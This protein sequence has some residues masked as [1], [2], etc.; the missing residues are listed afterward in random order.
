VKVCWS[1]ALAKVLPPVSHP[2]ELG[3]PVVDLPL[4]PSASAKAE[5]L[6]RSYADRLVAEAKLVA[7][8]TGAE[9]VSAAHMER[10]Y[11]AMRADSPSRWVEA[12]KVLGA[13]VFG[14]GITLFPIALEGTPINVMLATC[15]ALAGAIGLA[16]M[17][18]AVSR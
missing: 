3:K 18:W 9:H 13:A 11:H 5:E 7:F 10:A 17:V 14:V 1:S 6:A 16:L 8:R 12:A 4:N 15:G 2:I